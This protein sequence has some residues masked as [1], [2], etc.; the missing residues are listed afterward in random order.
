MR[1]SVETAILDAAE[2]V[3]ATQGIAAA[4]LQAIA[5]RAGV[6]VGTLY[7]YFE[8]RQELV[9]GMFAR[10]RA[11]L[12]DAIE[13]AARAHDGA[14]FVQQLDAF[15]RTVFEFFDQRRAFLRLALEAAEARPPLVRGK[16]GKRRPAMQQLEAHAERI[17]QVGIGEGRV[18]AGAPRLYA[19]VLASVMR[20]VL[21]DRSQSDGELKD[22]AEVVAELFL[23]G[24]SP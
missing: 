24:A 22:A 20:G 9:D 6:A 14:P 16:D 23:K 15:L 21:V 4:S 17:V 3:G 13:G 11:E 5:L 8:D 18:R 1:A 2:D 7:N 12:F 19:A 10:R